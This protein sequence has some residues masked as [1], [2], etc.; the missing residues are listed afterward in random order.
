MT[1]P[2]THRSV[3]DVLDR[4]AFGTQ[5]L[6]G[7]PMRA[8]TYSGAARTLKKIPDLAAARANGELAELKGIGKGMLAIVDA[9]LA[10]QAVPK[11]LELEEQIPPGLF[12]L[13]KLKGLGPKRI[14]TLWQELGITSPGELE[15][16]CNENRLVE[17]PGFGAA[18]QDKVKAG[19]ASLRESTSALRLDH[20]DAAARALT[21]RLLDQVGVERVEPTGALRRREEAVDAVELLALVDGVNAEL[22]GGETIRHRGL[23][24]ARFDD[25]DRELLVILCADPELWGVWHV[26]ITGGEEHVALLRERADRLDAEGLVVDGQPVPTWEEEDAYRA[27]GLLPTTPERR[28]SGVPLIQVGTERPRLVR[29]EDLRGA[30]HNHTT[31]SD[32]IHDLP[33][34]R[35]AAAAAGLEYLGISEHSQTA[36]YAG[37]L[38]PEALASQ[39]ATISELDDAGC[40]VLSGIESDILEDGSLDYS[41]ALLDGLDVVIASVHR[42]HR[43]DRAAATARMVAAASNPR[44]HVIGHPT[45]RLV[46]GRDPVDF[47]V[48]AMLDAAVASGCAVELNAHP[49]RLDLEPRWLMAAKER[50]VP[51][52]IAADAHSTQHLDHLDYG[53]DQARRAGLTPDDVLNCL[54]LADLRSWL[55]RPRA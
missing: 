33:T 40:V 9:V 37:G 23:P 31:A 45:G 42:R 6:G 32:G 17:L 54:P 7:S 50:G 24:A 16:A 35:A 52:S 8:R 11:L 38:S 27:L 30:L 22:L 53:I 47:D 4:I 51:V 15:Y 28:L 29:R 36:V 1:A 41:D 20:A 46:L 43:L 49:Q 5:L 18:T 12:A 44:V 13:R 26:L 39:A 48:L 25:D 3:P 14:A 19:L 34:M 10:G 21:E 2:V 55:S